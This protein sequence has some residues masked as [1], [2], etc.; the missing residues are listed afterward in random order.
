MSNL[1]EFDTIAFATSEYL[2]PIV[3]CIA[4]DNS[5]HVED[6]DVVYMIMFQLFFASLVEL[7]DIVFFYGNSKMQE[8]TAD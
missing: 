5:D 3:I 7:L 1:L 8:K 6:V 2:F 4:K